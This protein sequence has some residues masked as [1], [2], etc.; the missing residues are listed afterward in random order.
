MMLTGTMAN[1]EILSTKLRS[2]PNIEDA[3]IIRSPIVNKIY[4]PGNA[5]QVAVND[6]ERQALT[7]NEALFIDQDTSTMTYLKPMFARSDYK[8]TNCLVSKAQKVM[9]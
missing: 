7:G 1:R 5:N 6:A 8:G 4:G 3:H 9:Y 2:H